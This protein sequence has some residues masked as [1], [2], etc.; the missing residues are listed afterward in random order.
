MHIAALTL[1]ATSGANT[2][3][4]KTE[5]AEMAMIFPPIYPTR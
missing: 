1:D 5:S 3:L 2:L 4:V